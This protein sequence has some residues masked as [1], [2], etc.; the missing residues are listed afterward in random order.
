MTVVHEGAANM[1]PTAQTK[2]AAENP[3]TEPSRA[4]RPATAIPTTPDGDVGSIKRPTEVPIPKAANPTAGTEDAGKTYPAAEASP[5][6]ESPEVAALRDLVQRAEQGDLQVLPLLQQ[7]LDRNAGIWQHYG[8]LALRAEGALVQTTTGSNLLLAQ[9]LARKLTALKAE[10]A[11]PSA[12]P[13]ERLLVGEVAGCWLAKSYFD[14]RMAQSSGAT[15]AQVEMLRR[16]QGDAHRRF[17]QASRTLATV[18]KLLPPTP[19]AKPARPTRKDFGPLA[20][21][22]KG[23]FAALMGDTAER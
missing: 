20:D 19:A 23:S 11:G 5:A 15:A 12:T 6:V 8:D 4:W 14:A 1:S 18:R 10:L 16:L 22:L 17:L 7:A 2:P 9:S 21:R 13:L 3:G